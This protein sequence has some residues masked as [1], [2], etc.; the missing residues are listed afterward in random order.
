MAKKYVVRLNAEERSHLEEIVKKGKVAAYKRENAQILL[1]ADVGPAG[2]GWQDKQIAEA[3]DV[4]VRKVERLR[5]KLCTEGFESVLMKA[6]GQNQK[7]KIDGSDEAHLIALCCSSAPD[8]R[9]RWTL[10]LLAE[11]FVELEYVDIDSVS[12]E[13]IRQVLKKTN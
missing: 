8:G 4:S 7:R 6:S 10:R 1:K 9:A 3:F 11:K 5:K 2:A 13:T 12:H